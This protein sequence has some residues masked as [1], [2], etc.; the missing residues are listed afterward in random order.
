VTLPSINY[1]HGIKIL[2]RQLDSPSTYRT[3]YFTDRPNTQATA[4]TTPYWPILLSVSS[5]GAEMDEYLPRP[6]SGSFT[7]DNSIGTFGE[8][9]KF[10]DL[11][12]RYTAIHQPVEIHIDAI[13]LGSE[14]VTLDSNSRAWIARVAS[15][16]TSPDDEQATLTFNLTQDP[17][18]D[19]QLC[20]MVSEATLDVSLEKQAAGKWM[21]IAAGAYNYLPSYRLYQT[22]ERAYFGYATNFSTQ[23]R[24]YASGAYSRDVDGNWCEITSNITSAYSRGGAATSYSIDPSVNPEWVFAISNPSA[25]NGIINGVTFEMDPNGAGGRVSTCAVTVSLYERVVAAGDLSMRRLATGTANLSAFDTE[26][27]AGTNFSLVIGFDRAVTLNYGRTAYA[28]GVSCAQ[29][30]AGEASIYKCNTDTCTIWRRSLVGNYVS[31]TTAAAP[32]MTCTFSTVNDAAG[33]GYDNEGK[34]IAMVYLSTT[35]GLE[36]DDMWGSTDLIIKSAGI[37]DDISGTITGSAF[38]SITRPDHFI[39]LVTRTSDDYGVSW[40]A[41]TDWDWT[42]YAS[43]YTAHYTTSGSFGRV[44]LGYQDAPVTMRQMLE[45]VCR[46][47]ASRI[48]INADGTLFLWPW[49]AEATLAATIP[50]EDIIPVSWT[51]GDTSSIVNRVRIAYG[52]TNIEI[53]AFRNKKTKSN[54]TGTYDRIVSF[55]GVGQTLSLNSVAAWGRRELEISEVEYVG[56]ATSAATL[57]DHYMIRYA[58]PLILA[59][60]DVPYHKYSTVQLLQA[61]KFAHPAFPKY[62]GASPRHDEPIEQASDVSRAFLKSGR[63]WHAVKYWRG[64]VE[65]WSVDKPAGQAPRMKLLL[66]VLPN[67]PIDPT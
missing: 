15:I 18:P 30:A 7:I 34:R 51:I 55:R 36:P 5:F 11:L 22:S 6:F 13:A 4:D 47:S 32:A 38:T 24:H 52:V 67:Y 58:A 50:P 23:F 17:I 12:E 59:E 1:Y 21:P 2:L 8:G 31:T 26:N 57:V 33:L 28:I 25:Y 3:F 41:S 60:I 56:D 49:G 27:N 29:W 65:R 42:T 14:A 39:Q 44:L 63:H 45:G 53:V 19:S 20:T 37:R 46:D 9:R 35:S 40:D 54:Y 64:Q 43:A 10:S 62:H 61:V 16:D 66:R 48:G